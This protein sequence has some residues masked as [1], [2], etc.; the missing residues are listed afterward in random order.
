MRLEWVIWA[1]NWPH[2]A[3]ELTAQLEKEKE[4]LIP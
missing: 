1:E 2:T 4:C 3:A